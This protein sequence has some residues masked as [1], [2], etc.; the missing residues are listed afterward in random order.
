M[1]RDLLLKG[2]KS[3]GIF[4]D[5]NK[6]NMFEKY[7]VLLKEWNEKIN[8]TAITEDDEIVRKHFLDSISIIKSGL[9]NDNLKIIDVGTGAGFPG[10]PLKI[11]NPTLKVTLLDS[12]KK[13]VNF[14]NQVINELGLKNIEAVH[15]RAEDFA[16]LD[17]YREKYDISTARA[18]APMNILCEYCL[19][20][21]K[22]G[23]YFIAMKGPSIEEEIK[24]SKNAIGT[25]GGRLIDIVET[26]IPEYDV[27]HKLIIVGKI[28]PTD[29][30]Y[31]R[32]PSQIEKK[33]IK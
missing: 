2:A 20:F 12:L 26:S 27:N 18:V 33:P 21:V 25:L 10:I 32:K 9:I 3:Y 29:K 11:I 24:D 13:R 7:M 15:G 6:I 5:E 22:V 30:K 23:G 1:N 31:P 4:L 19:P 16:R 14:L 17:E 8:L 28:K